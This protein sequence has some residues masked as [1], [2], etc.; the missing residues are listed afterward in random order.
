MDIR[1]FLSRFWRRLHWFVLVAAAIGGGAILLARE[2][3]PTYVSQMRLL[4]EAPQI[5]GA[6]VV[7][8]PTQQLDIMEQRL[9]TRA[10]LLTIARAQDVFEDVR[11][12]APD[13]IVAR[14]QAATTIS[15]QGGRNPVPL[16]AISFAARSGPVA[17]D[18]LNAYLT[19]IQQEDVERRTVVAGQTLDFYDEE[20]ERL[21]GLLDER[22]ASILEFQ[23]ANADA[24]PEMLSPRMSQQSVLQD[25]LL[26]TDRDIDAIERQREQLLRLFEASGT[27]GGLDGD[28]AS[29]G[30]PSTQA[31]RNLAEIRARLQQALAVLS[32]TNPRVRVLRS[33]VAQAEAAVA[34]E[35]TLA[36][37]LAAD[38]DAAAG[39]AVDPRIA[40]RQALLDAQMAELASREEVLR[41]TKT[42]IET[43]LSGIAAMIERI[44]TNSIVLAGL[45]REYANVQAQYDAAVSR[46]SQAATGERIESLSRGQRIAVVEPPTVPSGPSGPDKVLIAGGGTA[47]GIVAGLALVVLMELLNGAP[48][49]P[50]DITAK[51]GVTPFATIP[52]VPTTKD[53]IRRRGV[54]VA[55]ILIGLV[56]VPAALY[57]VHVL[58]RPLDLLARDAARMVGL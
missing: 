54:K 26:Q 35:A 23:N 21:S 7:E 34:A 52:F 50:R 3:P 11:S 28:G 36:A 40:Q 25:R 57:A 20:V 32:D 10:N 4:V 56:G 15:R 2:M 49:R 18:V 45:E 16:V 47:A 30:A 9:L 14:M 39:E 55:I 22:S 58:Y 37:G 8:N 13:V 38:A 6:T 27:V 42:S 43:Q 44:P 1:Y 5:D 46:R 17:A 19:I 24:L 12:M 33:Q 51:L 48:R 53:T 31:E 29:S 41:E